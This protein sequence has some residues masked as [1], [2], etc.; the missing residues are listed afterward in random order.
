MFIVN[1]LRVMVFIIKK[2]RKL[3]IMPPSHILKR[4]DQNLLEDERRLLQEKF[5][6]YLI[7]QPHDPTDMK[8]DQTVTW[9]VIELVGKEYAPFKGV[10]TLNGI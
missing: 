4:L 2:S 10:A 9:E 1:H 3:K 8:I 6:D 5:I 7:L